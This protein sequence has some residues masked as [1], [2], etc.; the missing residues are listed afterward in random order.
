LSFGSKSDLL[1]VMKS[2]PRNFISHYK[3]RPFPRNKFMISLIAGSNKLIRAF[4]KPI[5]TFP[6]VEFTILSI[7]SLNSFMLIL[8]VNLSVI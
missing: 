2:I 4:V 1:S 3:E 7:F 8:T 5:S 6:I